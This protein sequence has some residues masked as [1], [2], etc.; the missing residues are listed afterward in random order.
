[1]ACSRPS[2]L[3]ERS[4][5]SG[6][7]DVNSPD[8]SKA[9]DAKRRKMATEALTSSKP[10]RL[11]TS[12]GT[13]VFWDLEFVTTIDHNYGA[14][15]DPRSGFITQFGAVT[16]DG[17]EKN[18]FVRPAGD[19]SWDGS[20]GKLLKKTP[21]NE[22][23][24]EEHNHKASFQPKIPTFKEAWATDI[25]PWLR[26]QQGTGNLYL[27]SHGSAKYAKGRFGHLEYRGKPL[28]EYTLGGAATNRS[29]VAGWHKIA[30]LMRTN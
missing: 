30:L 25:E 13:I 29:S 1:M 23:F 3:S 15:N 14:M 27:V 24:Y 26:Q 18:V 9:P 10:S 8:E 12:N 21:S 5:S 19:S 16:I 11:K 6:D 17:Q 22:G 4:D 28:D 7:S 2:T 20:Y